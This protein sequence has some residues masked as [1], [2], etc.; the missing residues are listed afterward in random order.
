[1]TFEGDKTIVLTKKAEACQSHGSEAGSVEVKG[2]WFDT[3]H[4]LQVTSSSVR[5]SI[6]AATCF[7][8][9][10]CL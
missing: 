10:I 4:D 5:H 7:G 3:A 1:M 2:H 8:I 9:V 6:H